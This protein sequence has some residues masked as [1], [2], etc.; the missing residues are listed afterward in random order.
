M[1]LPHSTRKAC[2]KVTWEGFP[3]LPNGMR[4]RFSLIWDIEPAIV[5]G[6]HR[7]A[8][9]LETSRLFGFG[10]HEFAQHR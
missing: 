2:A 9:L 5:A 4:R 1:V 10:T 8:Q 7:T 3:A 6:E